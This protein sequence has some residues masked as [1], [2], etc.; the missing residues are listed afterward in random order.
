MVLAVAAGCA[1]PPDSSPE[2]DAFRAALTF[3][4]DVEIMTVGDDTRGIVVR[5]LDRDGYA[6]VLAVSS[7]DKKLRFAFNDGDETFTTPTATNLDSNGRPHDAVVGDFDGN[8]TDD[9]AVTSGGGLEDV[10]VLW[11]DCDATTWSTTDDFPVGAGSA[12]AVAGQ[13]NDDP[14]DD[15]AVVNRTGDDVSILLAKTEGDAPDFATTDEAVGDDPRGV[16]LGDFGN[17]RD[18]AAVSF[19]DDEVNCIENDGSYTTTDI[20]LV[21]GDEPTDLAVADLDE[22]G[23]DDIVAVLP[24]AD[25]VILLEGNATDCGFDAAVTIATGITGVSFVDIA[26][27]DMNGT[28]DVVVGSAGDTDL[29][30]LPGNGDGTFGTAET[31]T[32]GHDVDGGFA[33]A[34]LNNDDKVDIV[35]ASDDKVYWAEMTSWGTRAIYD[36]DDMDYAGTPLATNVDCVVMDD[37]TSGLQDALD[38]AGDNAPARVQLPAGRYCLSSPLTVPSGVEV[39]GRGPDASYLTQKSDGR[40]IFLL[41]E[42]RS[43]IVRNIHLEFGE[44]DGTGNY[45]SVG[46]AIYGSEGI[47]VQGLEVTDAKYGILLSSSQTYMEK[48]ILDSGDICDGT[49]T[50]RDVRVV[51][52]VVES[53]GASGVAVY[54]ATWSEVARN[55]LRSS[56]A[57]DGLKASCGP[58]RFNRFVDNYLF[59]N[60]RDGFDAAWVEDS[61][62]EP[63]HGNVFAYNVSYDNRLQGIDLKSDGDLDFCTAERFD[64]RVGTV[65]IESNVL[66]NNGGYEFGLQRVAPAYGCIGETSSCAKGQVIGNVLWSDGSDDWS[67][68]THFASVRNV[69]F[70]DNYSDG[71][72]HGSS[73]EEIL[74]DRNRDYCVEEDASEGE[75]CAGGTGMG[76]VCTPA[77]GGLICI[78]NACEGVAH[79]KVIPVSNCEVEFDGGTAYLTLD[80]NYFTETEQDG[81]PGTP[82]ELPDPLPLPP[83]PPYYLFDN[84]NSPT[85]AQRKTMIDDIFNKR[86]HCEDDDGDG[87]PNGYEAVLGTDPLDDSETPDPGSDFLAGE[88]QA[89]MCN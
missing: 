32:M 84:T 21:A 60:Y 74:C 12:N 63:F 40:S 69:R 54:Q 48:F 67:A 15:I 88:C 66:V 45:K 81:D 14:L 25:D 56:D 4:S 5:D 8:G 42:V 31:Y 51:D 71:H 65:R 7:V 36:A 58:V 20:A 9:V 55:H 6:D 37:H 34:D 72:A 28:L 10:R 19:G 73:C 49:H 44:D 2:L 43:S 50:N 76:G 38:D 59:D 26:D 30:F 83:P 62:K 3:S 47:V 77:D 52:N 85:D 70:D 68:G 23:K 79:A 11:G 13:I 61:A 82:Y 86:Y 35:Y 17:T 29:T 16:A 24:G 89:A 46:V 27:L 75:S 57:A 22:D 87:C 18:L 64:D 39:L 78:A 41:D 33:L 1:P 80:G 53:S